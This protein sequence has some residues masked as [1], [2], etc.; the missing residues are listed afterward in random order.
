MMGVYHPRLL[1]LTTPSYTFN[2]RFTAP[3]AP[4]S[5]RVGYPD[6]T[7]R[8]SR[9]FRHHDHK[10][11]WTVEEFRRWCNDAAEE[12]GYSVDISSVGRAMERDEW[13]RDEELGGASQVA[14]FRRTEG[15]DSAEKRAAKS[16]DA[17]ERA[18]NRPKHQLLTAQ[19][20]EAHPCSQK[21]APSHVIGEAVRLKMETNREIFMRLEELWFEQDI[22]ILCG[23]WI[24]LLVDAVE[25]N[26]K[27]TLH[28]DEPQRRSWRV[29]LRDGVENPR[30]FW[31]TEDTNSPDYFPSDYFPE[32]PPN[33][34]LSEAESSGT[35]G[36]ISADNSGDEE[37]DGEEFWGATVNP[38]VGLSAAG[39]ATSPH[40]LESDKIDPSSTESESGEVWG[41]SRRTQREFRSDSSGESNSGRSTDD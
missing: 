7:G 38:A 11:E 28:K 5:A 1:L 32:D 3:D 39:W 17:A 4:S 13:G 24:E 29:E 6:P 35:D 37:E 18:S 40:G 22:A 31:P 15:K 27:L 36:D 30:D 23:G 10:F 26:E 9:V 21:P 20:H 25:E 12:W 2:A 19:L 41:R 33:S 16:K 8:T 34:L 14:A